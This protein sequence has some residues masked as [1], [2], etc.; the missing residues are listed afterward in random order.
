VRIHNSANA[1]R[2]DPGWIDPTPNLQSSPQQV[3]LLAQASTECFL[4]MLGSKTEIQAGSYQQIRVYLAT[5]TP[6]FRSRH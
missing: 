5:T 2:N 4:A 1:G 3:D 6:L